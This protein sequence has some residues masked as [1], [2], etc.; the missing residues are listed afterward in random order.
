MKRYM[1]ILILFCWAMSC[2][3]S[4]SIEDFAP[5]TNTDA[6]TDTNTYTDTGTE[7]GTGTGKE[8]G[9]VT[10]KEAGTNTATDTGT[11][12]GIETGTETETS[13]ETNTETDTDTL[14]YTGTETGADTDTSV[15]DTEVKG[16]AEPIGMAVVS[17]DGVEST[18]GGGDGEVVTA[19]S[20]G[21][22]A[23]YAGST[24]PLYIIVEGELS[25]GDVEVNSNKTIIGAG[26]GAT[27]RGIQLNMAGEQ[28]GVQKENIII[29]NLTISG[30][31]DGIATRQTHHVWIDHLDVSSCGDGLI[32]ITKEADYH[33]VSWTRFRDHNKT[34]L[35]NSGTNKEE[36]A[37]D[38]NVTLHHNWWDGATRRNPRAAY[39][40][41]H[42]FNCM[43]NN[44]DAFC[45]GIH[46]RCM[47]L[48]E[49]NY[50]QNTNDPI[51]QCYQED[52]SHP[53]HGFAKDVGS[54][55]DNTTGA[56]D[57]E[58]EL[59]TVNFEEQYYL[60]RFA[61][62]AAADVPAFVQAHAGPG[63]EYSQL[64]PLPVPGNGAVSVSTSPTL[65]WT[66]GHTATGY[67][68]SFGATN[69][70]PLVGPTTE[71]TFTPGTLNPRTVYYWRV[72]QETPEGVKAG[73]LW[74]FRTQ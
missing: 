57:N 62:D 31:T 53:D 54:I 49:H 55:F 4:S 38:M 30:A 74:R 56:I 50:F 21:E 16:C 20:H 11:E 34:M 13:T 7:T 60:Y 27:L 45:I 70:P 6:D 24:E 48:S 35:I 73:N 36:D 61:L 32:D 63:P 43:Y 66:R 18:T 10:D 33:T 3:S 72:D 47:V 17:D 23:E 14:T 52:P 64:G 44:N 1:A 67:Q 41:I 37:D 15:E 59:M 26:S 68:V 22:L 19:R 28:G 65:R 25:G 39:G 12:A 42:I 51:R 40:D 58:D 8:A 46:S 71:Q 5:G 2:D 29:R 69:P 9:K